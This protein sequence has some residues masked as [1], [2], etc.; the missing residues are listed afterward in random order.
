MKNFSV[1]TADFDSLSIS[2][3]SPIVQSDL[4]TAPNQIPLNKDL[5]SLAY[6]DAPE[7]E[8]LNVD[9]LE[10]RE[11][12]AE[13][14]ETAVDV[15]VYDTR[16]DSDGGAWR[17][18]TSHTSW[19]NEP[20]NTA[21]RGSRREFPAVAVIVAEAGKVTI[22]D[23]DDPDLSM[24]MVFDDDNAGADVT[25]VGVGNNIQAVSALNGRMSVGCST[26]V[27]FTTNFIVDECIRV[28]TTYFF[29]LTENTA[30]RN[31]ASGLIHLGGDPIVN[32][33]VN[34]VAMTVLP[35]APIDSETGLPI[36]TIAVA[37]D[38]GYSII[39]DDGTV[40]DGICPQYLHNK[41]EKIA[42]TD[43]NRVTYIGFDY[44]LSN[45]GRFI[46]VDDLIS[47][48]T[49]ITT[50]ADQTQNSSA[51]YGNSAS[52]D[53]AG[54]L[55][56]NISV[57]T[58]ES[59]IE[60]KDGNIMFGN[61]QNLFL[62]DENRSSPSKGM[63]AGISTDFNTGWMPGNIKLATL[64]DTK[65]EKVG[66]DETELV[67]NGGF[68][69][70]RTGWTDISV[71]S[72]SVVGS[73]L[74]VEYT[75]VNSPGVYQDFEIV[76][77]KTYTLSGVSRSSTEGQPAKI[78]IIEVDSVGLT[79]LGDS[80]SENNRLENSTTSNVLKSGRFLAASS[81]V[82]RVRLQSN[83]T[84]DA[85]FDNISVKQTG[86]LITNGTFDNGEAGWTLG[87]GWS[88]S[89]GAATASSCPE[90]AS[91]QSDAFSTIVG[92]KYTATV[93]ITSWTAGAIRIVPRGPAVLLT[94]PTVNSIGTHSV[95]FIATGTSSTIEAQA[96]GTTTSL[97]IDNFSVRLAEDDR[98][99]NNNGLQ[100]FGE[101]DK[102]P[103]APGADLVAYSGFSAD[104]YLMQPYNP[105]L[106]FGTGD[107]CV[108]GWFNAGSS[109]GVVK[110]I[111]GKYSIWDLADPGYSSRIGFNIAIH[112]D[113]SFYF[114]SKSDGKLENTP[115][116]N[117]GASLHTN[118]WNHFCVNRTGGYIKTYING[119][120][121]S[122][123]ISNNINLSTDKSIYIGSYP[124]ASHSSCENGLSLIRISK[125]AP[126]DDQI[127]KIYRDEKVLFQDGAQ[128]TLHGTSDA[129]TALA[130]DDSDD[131]LHVGTASGRSSFNGLKRVDNTTTAV[132]TAISATEG[133]VIEQ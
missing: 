24:W 3:E 60:G 125:T 118:T 37:T 1:K 57:Y 105:D 41:V 7:I 96:I 2:G 58:G 20:L 55:N 113:G 50:A 103:V 79:F 27:I 13:M 65:N 8:D 115:Y 87:T 110:G 100:I 46:R 130:Y 104:D 97:L 68:D 82:I 83:F 106:D 123:V 23:G 128:A 114:Y 32:G 86:E 61:V 73:E 15:F 51:F 48:D 67:T 22:Y 47:V 94:G 78:S 36:A 52:G 38:G 92:K 98:S 85:Y 121:Y 75:T 30:G 112:T 89:G 107:F 117:A 120:E 40:V 93:D 31:N 35:N 64:S 90:F 69:S 25:Y 119:S 116:E 63:H 77:G 80:W 111:M 122:S 127:A 76:A 88:I 91:I 109:T 66:V 102:S 16:K 133:L 11:I 70:D 49:T 108:M 56:L 129:V 44:N 4:G 99:V 62:I 28:N 54:N 84:S 12:A 21:T 18:R 42:F 45:R 17:S 6:M 53:F 59:F 132:T 9:T 19:Y 131:L 81:G 124:I 26:Y 33:S 95:T 126:T 10:L 29:S 101:I 39:K 71:G 43:D 5:G 34:D 14:S 74:F 72:Y